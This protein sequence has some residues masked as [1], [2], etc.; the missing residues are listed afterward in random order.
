MPSFEERFYRS[1]PT[2]AEALRRDLALLIALARG[3]WQWLVPGRRL[4]QAVAA[5]RERGE[6]VRLEE[7][8]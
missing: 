6:Q 3:L 7:L 8:P 4:R 1:N 2:R 5:A